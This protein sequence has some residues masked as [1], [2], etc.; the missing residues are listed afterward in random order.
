MCTLCA[1]NHLQERWLSAQRVMAIVCAS[2]YLSL[3]DVEE[4]VWVAAAAEEMAEAQRLVEALN[5]LL[6]LRW[7]S[8]RWTPEHKINTSSSS[9][10]TTGKNT[11][12]KI[13]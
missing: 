11:S 12:T 10:H 7:R 9:S 8:T 3:Y 13:F 5:L 2:Y 6:D 1:L 4:E